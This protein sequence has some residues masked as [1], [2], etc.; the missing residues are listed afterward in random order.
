MVFRKGPQQYPYF[1]TF[2]N[3]T[4]NV[5]TK[6]N[7]NVSVHKD[8][9]NT[10]AVQI[11][12]NIKCTVH[13]LNNNTGDVHKERKNI[14]NTQENIGNVRKDHNTGNEHREY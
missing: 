7:N 1:N 11:H 14:S 5:H 8:L 13:K 2:C 9:R 3:N 10:G 6:H 12:Y 4:G